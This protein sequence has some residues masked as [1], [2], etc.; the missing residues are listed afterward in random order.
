M[1][2]FQRKPFWKPPGTAAMPRMPGTPSGLPRFPA[3]VTH[4]MWRQVVLCL[5]E[6]HTSELQWQVS[7][8]LPSRHHNRHSNQQLY[9]GPVA[10]LQ[11][12]LLSCNTATL[13][14][15]PVLRSTFTLDSLRQQDVRTSIIDQMTESDQQMGQDLRVSYGEGVVEDPAF[16]HSCTQ[17]LFSSGSRS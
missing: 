6:C 2:P 14:A 11:I 7:S 16:C 8:Q 5:K 1:Q 12:S 10:S 4:L 13:D 9:Q 15:D 17:T 3:L